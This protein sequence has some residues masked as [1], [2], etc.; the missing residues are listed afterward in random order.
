M[1]GAA[2]LCNMVS[3]SVSVAVI[4]LVVVVEINCLAVHYDNDLG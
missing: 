4:L 2:V 1:E 3:Y